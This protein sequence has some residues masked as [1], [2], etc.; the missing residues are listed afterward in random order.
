M[1]RAFAKQEG[2]LVDSELLALAGCVSSTAL[3]GVRLV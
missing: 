2:S 3:R 1:E